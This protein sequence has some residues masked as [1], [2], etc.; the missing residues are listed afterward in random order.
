[1][2]LTS[3]RPF[4]LLHKHSTY[5]YVPLT[6]TRQK[7][8]LQLLVPLK[9]A[10]DSLIQRELASLKYLSRSQ[11]EGIIARTERSSHWVPYATDFAT[12]ECTLIWWTV[13][14]PITLLR[15]IL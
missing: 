11:K 10:A 8:L 3:L 9:Q 5:S 4:A 14:S 6:V 1:M 15:H 7:Y 12:Y 2:A 13:P